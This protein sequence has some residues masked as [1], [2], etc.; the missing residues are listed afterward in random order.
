MN[1]LKK[2]FFY[3]VKTP[4]HVDTDIYTQ[5]HVYKEGENN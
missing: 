1:L 4:E 5:V 3:L 2:T